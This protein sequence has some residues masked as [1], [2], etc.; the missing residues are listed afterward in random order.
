MTTG[1]AVALAAVILVAAVVV[2]L[3]VRSCDRKVAALT[4]ENTEARKEVEKWRAMASD[5]RDQVVRLKA[6]L[7]NKELPD[8]AAVEKLLEGLNA[9][10]HTRPVLVDTDGGAGTE[11]DPTVVSGS[12]RGEE[13]T[14]P[15]RSTDEDHG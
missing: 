11:A 8:D 6:S 7:A 10:D 1:L 13:P 4:K 12:N 3:T 9:F 15:D 14:D 5:L 2:W